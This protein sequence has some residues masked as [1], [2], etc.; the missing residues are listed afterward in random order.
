LTAH[1]YE[2]LF[3]WWYQWCAMEELI[4]SQGVMFVENDRLDTM[5]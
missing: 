1:K 5:I 4:V 3:S 2:S